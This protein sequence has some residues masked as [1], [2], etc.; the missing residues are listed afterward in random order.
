MEHIT[1]NPVFFWRR[2]NEL[3][4]PKR[5]I[6]YLT[7]PNSLTLPNCLSALKNVVA[8]RSI[9]I[10]VDSIINTGT[11]GHHW[12]EYSKPELLQY[13][14]ALDAHVVSLRRFNYDLPLGWNDFRR[15][16]FKKRV[17]GAAKSVGRTI[18]VFREQLECIVSFD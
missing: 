14:S 7:T 4:A 11:Y 18:P 17:W 6:V 9:G 3:L 8:L 13:F 5:G 15:E 12:K 1:Y 2:I 10:R 16:G